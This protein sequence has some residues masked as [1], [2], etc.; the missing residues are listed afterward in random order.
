MRKVFFVLAMIILYSLCF[1]Q[2]ESPTVATSSAYVY[3]G[4]SGTVD[5]LK[6]Y[7]YIWGQVRSPGLYL[8]PDNTD[9]LTLISLAGGPN[10]N[11]KMS[12]VR[13]V[14]QTENGEKIIWVD[15][16]DYIETAEQDLIPIMMPGDTVI[17]SGSTFYAFSR[18]ADFLSKV[19]IVLS[20]YNM[21]ANISK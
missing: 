15:L 4:P 7:T 8:V 20:V 3:S 14:R 11:A 1:A 10:E 9:L 13:I 6:I 21:I 12:R 5:Q 16:R 17:L 19:V 18:V 2:S